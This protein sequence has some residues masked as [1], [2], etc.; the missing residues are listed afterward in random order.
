MFHSMKLTKAYS[1]NTQKNPIKNII[2]E[3]YKFIRKKLTELR[4]SLLLYTELSKVKNKELKI[5]LLNMY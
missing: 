1:Y 2:N 5:Y 4:G 3:R